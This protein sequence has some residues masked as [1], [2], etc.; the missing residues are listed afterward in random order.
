MILM[1]MMSIEQRLLVHPEKIS[2]EFVEARMCNLL[3]KLL[4][5]G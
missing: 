1:A 2:E 3:D 4:P 5:R